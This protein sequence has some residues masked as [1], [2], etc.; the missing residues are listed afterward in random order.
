M[1]SF[2]SLDGLLRLADRKDVDIRPTLLRV[3]TDLY[4]QKPAH[5]REE[6]L[7]YTE[8]A[9]RLIE[10]VDVTTRRMVAT[11]LAGYRQAPPA[12]VARLKR[13]QAEVAAP[14]I[15]HPS[16][17]APVD[18]GRPDNG[19]RAA[20]APAGKPAAA[21]E[22]LSEVFFAASASERR[23]ILLNLA[24]VSSASPRATPPAHAL[25][26]IRRL[27]RAALAR[28]TAEFARHLE[29]VLG[30]PS[31]QTRRIAEDPSGEPIVV[32]AK[33]IGMPAEVLHRILLFL[34][35]VIGHSVRRVFDLAR[36]YDEITPQAAVHLLAIWRRSATPPRRQSVH[37][38]VYWDDPAEHRRLPVTLPP[39]QARKAKPRNESAGGR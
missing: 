1:Q 20:I 13:D 11:R 30:L 15:D 35:P 16:L 9:L 12:V 18:G 27:E 19:P 5:S 37:Q 39:Q 38:R 8:L 10:A 7:H 28:N 14:F 31:A 36:L 2:P 29:G 4:V 25:D 3:L 32:V 33:A 17:R 24:Y 22:D 21:S 26:A 34:N 23:V 6:E